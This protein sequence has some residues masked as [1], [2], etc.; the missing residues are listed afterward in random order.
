L[1]NHTLHPAARRDFSF[2]CR[3]YIFGIS[4]EL[5]PL[6]STEFLHDYALFASFAAMF[7]PQ[8]FEIESH[9]IHDIFAIIVYYNTQKS[10]D[11]S[12]AI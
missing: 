1:R 4:F 3:E 10:S 9:R 8:W 5:N 6:F 2:F 7:S 12:L 11:H